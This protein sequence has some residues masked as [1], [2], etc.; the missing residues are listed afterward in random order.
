MCAFS[1]GKKNIHALFIGKLEN[2][3]KQKEKKRQSSDQS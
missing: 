2:N 3:S 1:N